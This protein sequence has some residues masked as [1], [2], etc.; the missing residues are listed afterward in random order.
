MDFQ[1]NTV[2]QKPDNSKAGNI[3]DCSEEFKLEMENSIY[4]YFSKLK[5]NDDQS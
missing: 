3:I 5:L 2:F 4:N 1:E